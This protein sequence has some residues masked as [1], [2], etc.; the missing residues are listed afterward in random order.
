MFRFR[1]GVELPGSWV[2]EGRG[3]P[4]GCDVDKHVSPGA[5][6]VPYEAKALRLEIGFLHCICQ[7][8]KV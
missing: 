5:T 2:E 8:A 3:P 6:E 7:V 4:A 1:F